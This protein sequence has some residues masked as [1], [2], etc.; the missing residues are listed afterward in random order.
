MI[1]NSLLSFFA[2]VL[3]LIIWEIFSRTHAHLLFVLPP[4]SR[5]I[6]CCWV[7]ADRLLMHTWVTIKEI[8]GGILLALLV[9]FPLAWGMTKSHS[10]R[11]ILQPLFIVI[12]C[13]PMF[14]LAPIMVL[15]FGWSYVSIVIPTMLMIF[16]PL[17]INIF[18]GLCS[19]P[20]YLLDYFRIHQATPW[21]TFWKLQ[22]PWAMP[23]LFAGFRIAAAVA[24]LC[25][26]AG[27]W[28]GGQA[29]LGLLMIESRRS[30]DLE[31]TFA[32][33]AYLTAVSLCL[34][35]AVLFIEKKVARPSRSNVKNI[36]RAGYMSLALSFFLLSGCNS[37]DE[38]TA[39]ETRL[40]LDWLPNPNHIPIYTG[41]EKGFFLK[42]GI[43]LELLKLHDPGDSLS[44]LTTN[45]ANLAV[46][47]MP[48][49]YVANTQGAN[50]TPVGFLIKQPLNAFIFPE[51]EGIQHPADLNGK[52]I[53]YVVGSFGL[54]LLN[55]M[56]EYKSIIPS[57]LYNVNFDLVSTLG[58]KQI[59]AIYGAYW[60]IEVEH[61]RSLGINTAFFPL[62]DFGS[63][64]H[65]ELII[66]AKE[67]SAWSE[68]D[69]VARF[70][71]ALQ[72]SIDYSVAHPD[73]AFDIYMRANPDKSEKTFAWERQAWHKTIPLL[74]EN[75]HN[76]P[77]VW[78]NFEAW[79]K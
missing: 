64:N 63:P 65:Y 51:G 18:Q 46:Y 8:G 52:K 19:T 27:E 42:H 29:G 76:D 78:E 68:S 66:I 2:F 70:Q 50:L 62:S 13:V 25:A 41:I 56:L 34:Y 54:T 37:T 22:L 74:A 16:F 44:L 40:I 1:K 26:V 59:D 32:A 77:A 43:E 3:L 61:L 5:I 31:M 4:P 33:L 60:N 58:T 38:A 21:Q 24:G 49:T 72:Q 36:A 39:K 10:L 55:K 53:G 48:E 14:A 75:Q 73:A 57:A 9:S 23:N 30:T 15:W 28:A 69:F 17:T 35:S 79:T 7:H 20:T 12:Q 11:S 47:Y 6:K 67:G 71:A 45:R